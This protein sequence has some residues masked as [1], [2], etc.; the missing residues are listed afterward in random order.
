MNLTPDFAILVFYFLWFLVLSFFT[1][2]VYS[3][4]SKIMRGDKKESIIGLLDTVLKKE[5]ENKKTIDQLS[6]LC[7]KLKSDG[8]SH[9]QKIGLVRF[10]PFR[11][12][13]GDQSFI[14][15]LVD[16]EDTG[17]VISSL[18]TRTGTRWYAK[19]VVKGKGAE[20]ELSDDERKAL[21]GAELLSEK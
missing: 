10:N 5:Q 6:E 12:T 1:F 2:K 19:N 13:G 8:A 18:H 7:D 14:L 9:I 21:R 16:A 11:E 20:Y 17:V 15:A 4:N 3:I